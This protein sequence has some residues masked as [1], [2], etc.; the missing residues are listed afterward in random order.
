MIAELTIDRLGHRAD[1][2]AATDGDRPIYVAGAL[3]GERVRAEILGERGRLLDVL[4]PSPDR[5][6]PVCPYVGTC[7]GCAIQHLAPEPYATW[8]RGLVA[9]ALRTERLEP[10]IAPLVDAHGQGR[11]RITLHARRGIVGYAQARSHDLVAIQACP[12]ASPRLNAGLPALRAV[13]VSL[14][15]RGK[16]LDLLLTTTRTGLDLD[17]HGAGPVD[18]APR[19]ALSEI[20]ARHDLARLSVHGDIVVERRAPTVAFAGTDV[21]P[22]PGAF[23]QATEAGEAAL[24]ALVLA[25]VGTARRVGDLFCGSGTFALA[26]ARRASVKACDSHPPAVAALERGRRASGLKPIETEVRDL[27]RRPLLAD[28][29]KTLDAVVFDPPRAGAEAQ[30]R[31]LARST[32]RRVVGVSCNPATFARDAKILVAG[33]FRLTAVTPVDQFRYSAHVELV[34]TFVR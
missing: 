5:I 3:P 1:G 25:G 8:K 23:L 11:R 17:V 14:R 7:G 21:V 16:A 2:V 6:E 9:D 30:A 22:P 29:L 26:L 32:V 13:E 20:A 10:E 27:M 31:Q 15:G 19:I 12:I 34:G 18:G 24:T 28:E 4:I 33:G